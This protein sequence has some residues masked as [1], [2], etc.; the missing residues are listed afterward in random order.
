MPL[1]LPRV[2]I[3]FEIGALVTS[4]FKIFKNISAGPEYSIDHIPNPTKIKFLM[5]IPILTSAQ[6]ILKLK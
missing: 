5:K 2:T 1:G 4:K 3:Q 6:E